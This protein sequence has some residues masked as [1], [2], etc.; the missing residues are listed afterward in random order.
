MRRA[1][2]LVNTSAATA[3]VFHLQMR[4]NQLKLPTSHDHRLSAER[5]MEAVDKDKS[6]SISMNEMLKELMSLRD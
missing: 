5:F 6:G 3:H 4:D 2:L 1:I